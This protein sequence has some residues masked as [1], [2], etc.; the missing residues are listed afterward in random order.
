MKCTKCGA[1]NREGAKF[2]NECAAPTE[3]SCPRCGSRNKPGAK[4]CDECGATLDSSAPASPKKP[5]DS[6]IRVIDSAVAENLDGERK[7]VTALFADIKGSM[8]LM[9]DLDPEEARAIVDP[10]LN[11]MID[12][13]RRY[14]GFVVQ[15]TGDGVFALFGAP[16]ADGP[17]APPA[18]RTARRCHRRWIALRNRRSAALPRSSASAPDR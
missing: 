13:V 18:P 2:C 6:S 4:F 9:E 10:S 5:N 11:L 7:T 8:E 1:E 12:A 17:R 15:S 3:G 16:V 14:D